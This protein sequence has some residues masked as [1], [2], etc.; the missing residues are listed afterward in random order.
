MEL[1][2]YWQ[3]LWQYW[4]VVGILTLVGVVAALLYYTSNPPTY[5]A[6][7]TV[8]VTQQ[9]APGD[10]YSNIYANQASDY[11][12]DELVKIIPGNV[13]MSAVST[14]L[15]E[16]NINFTPDELKGMIS[17]EP[18]N[19]TITITVNNGDQNAALKIAQTVANTLQNSVAEYLKP[20]QVLVKVID[21]PSQSNLRGGRTVLLAVIRVLA[22]LLAG[23]GLAFLLAYLDNSIRNKNEL[24][25]LLGVPVMGLIPVAGKLEASHAVQTVQPREDTIINARLNSMQRPASMGT[26]QAAPP[27]P[28]VLYVPDLPTVVRPDAITRPVPFLE[29][30]SLEAA[31]T[32]A[33]PAVAQPGV[34]GV[35]PVKPRRV[36]RARK[37]QTTPDS[38]E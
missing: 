23:V 21:F 13:F 28:P 9:P 20:R 27:P 19:R 3:I 7:A 25:E 16:G 18:K 8:N 10:L 1:R 33:F 22:G 11:S 31:R 4:L 14:Q 15:K 36:S 30:A 6:T 34:A 17:L 32:E 35:A 2:R 5:Q 37:D 38:K 12:T 29:A 24:E 26:V